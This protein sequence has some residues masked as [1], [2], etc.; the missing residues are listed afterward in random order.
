MNLWDAITTQIGIA[1]GVQEA[2][3]IP[4]G[5]LQTHGPLGL[6]VIKLAITLLVAA[7][8]LLLPHRRRLL[9]VLYVSVPLLALVVAN[10]LVRIII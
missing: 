7:T 9:Y 3:P 1:T 5:I 4:A 8:V 10:N 2:N 6:L